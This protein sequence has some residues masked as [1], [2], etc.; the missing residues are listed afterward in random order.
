MYEAE[1]MLLEEPPFIPVYSYVNK[2]MVNPL[3]KGW[4]SNVLDHHYSKDMFLVKTAAEVAAARSATPPATEIAPAGA[5]EGSPETGPG[6]ETMQ[7]ETTQ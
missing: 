4:R 6:P 5:G 2:R 1:R 3:L 7:G